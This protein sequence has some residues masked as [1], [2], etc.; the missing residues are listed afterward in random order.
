MGGEEERTKPEKDG[1]AYRAV[2]D[3]HT[4]KGAWREAGNPECHPLAVSR[5]TGARR[6]TQN[7]S[8]LVADLDHHHRIQRSARCKERV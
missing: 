6:A 5:T 2:R 3:T 7:E 8:H 1:R 4:H